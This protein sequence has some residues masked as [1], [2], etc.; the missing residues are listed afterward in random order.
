MVLSLNSGMEKKGASTGKSK[1]DKCSH[2]PCLLTGRKSGGESQ[3]ESPKSFALYQPLPASP[4]GD[5]HPGHC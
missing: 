5:C 3:V 4:K 1:L 2:A